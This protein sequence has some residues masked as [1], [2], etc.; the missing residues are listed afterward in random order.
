MQKF[1][2]FNEFAEFLT[3]SNNRKEMLKVLKDSLINVNTNE[4]IK[5][6]EIFEL[7]DKKCEIS[8]KLETF[9]NYYTI[10][11]NNIWECDI[12]SKFI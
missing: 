10:R 1:I 6:C 2:N 11:I 9:H 12:I 7:L 8:Q 3:G 4:Y 5:E